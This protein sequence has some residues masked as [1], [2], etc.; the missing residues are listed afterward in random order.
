MKKFLL[1]L[2]LLLG[3]F[4]LLGIVTLLSPLNTFTFRIWEALVVLERNSF[5]KGPFYPN[6]HLTMNEE[7]DLANG[8]PGAI[9]ARRPPL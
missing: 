2:T 3:P 8:T 5:L 7:G 1:K 9:A 4:A 6:Q